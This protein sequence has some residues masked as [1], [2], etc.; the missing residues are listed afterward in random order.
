MRVLRLTPVQNARVVQALYAVISAGGRIAPVDAEI[1]SV[2]AIQ[3]HLFL[4]QQPLRGTPGP[5]PDDLAGVLTTPELRVQVVRLMAMLPPLDKRLRLEKVEVVEAAARQLGVAEF[6]LVMLRRFALKQHK[7]IVPRLA[8]R[9]ID[10]YWSISGRP[11]PR[12]WLSLWWSLT[13]WFPGLRRRLKLDELLA[14]Y[15]AL[16]RLPAGTLGHAIHAYYA[17]NGFPIPGAP[18][19]IPEGW[20]RHEVYHVVSSYGTTVPG[21][22][23]LAAFIAGNTTEL[24]LDVVLPALL[25]FH[26]GR[27]LLAGAVAEDTFRPDEFFRAMARGAMMSVDLLA[28]WQIWE[29]AHVELDELR[30]LYQLPPLGDEERRLLGEQDALLA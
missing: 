7:R 22:L 10:H 6:G 28:G 20:A 19:S 30:A 21:E 24:A 27:R 9:L 14:R 16:E 23:L 3:R 2:D 1:A 26:V 5:L 15:E 8:K 29:H 4:Q 18:K 11:E 12:G 17:R 13:P 25:Q